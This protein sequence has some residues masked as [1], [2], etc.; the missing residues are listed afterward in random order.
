MKLNVR[1]PERL[2]FVRVRDYF[3]NDSGWT[4]EVRE[5]VR[6]EAGSEAIALVGHDKDTTS[7]YLRWFPEWERLEIPCAKAGAVS[8]HG[9]EIRESFLREAKSVAARPDLSTATKGWLTSFAD[10]DAYRSLHDEQ[11]AIDGYKKSWASAPF[12][13]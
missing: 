11:I 5:K 12:P 2:R 7:S 10:T 6:E 8:L 13:P 3:Y 4:N 1:D 9:T